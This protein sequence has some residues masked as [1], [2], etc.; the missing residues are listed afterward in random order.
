MA[1]RTPNSRLSFPPLARLSRLDH[2]SIS[3][4]PTPHESNLGPPSSPNGATFHICKACDPADVA[5]NACGGVA[6]GRMD[7]K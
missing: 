6:L 1:H 5:R 3:S 4:I 7:G 2:T